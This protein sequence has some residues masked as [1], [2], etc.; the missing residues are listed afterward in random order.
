MDDTMDK[1]FELIN[2]SLKKQKRNI[3]EVA[4]R[5]RQGHLSSSFSVDDILN[6]LYKKIY[7]QFFKNFII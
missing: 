7:I 4:Y 2:E 1:R 6:I 3:I 5:A